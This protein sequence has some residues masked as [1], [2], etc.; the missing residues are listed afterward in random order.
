MKE[1]LLFTI[2]KLRPLYNNILLVLIKFVRKSE[3]IISS[4]HLHFTFYDRFAPTQQEASK[5]MIHNA[6]QRKHTTR[7]FL[8]LPESS[9]SLFYKRISFHIFQIPESFNLI[10][11][12]NK[13]YFIIFYFIRNY[14]LKIRKFELSYPMQSICKFINKLIKESTTRNKH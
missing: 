9:S 5:S 8:Y 4:V 6:K 13:F 10:A 12:K 2:Y 1:K 11:E 14:L 3:I 7:P